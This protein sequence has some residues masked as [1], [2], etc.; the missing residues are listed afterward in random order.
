[1]NCSYMCVC[2]HTHTQACLQACAS[3]HPVTPLNNNKNTVS[4]VA[5]GLRTRLPMAE[6]RVRPGIQE[7]PTCCGATGPTRH[8]C[9]A[10]A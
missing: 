10:G 7:D 1:M 9:R 8:S 4:P 6:T 5:L 2:A 3:V